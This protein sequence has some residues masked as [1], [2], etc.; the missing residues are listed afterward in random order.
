MSTQLPAF[1]AAAALGPHTTVRQVA[2]LCA[3]ADA[4]GQST[5]DY[6]FRLGMS[7]PVVSRAT[8]VLEAAGMVRRA[9]PDIDRRRVQIMLTYAGS[10]LVAALG[11]AA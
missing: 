5:Q 2:L 7:K 8:D 1:L 6:S 9:T 4:P 11:A 10:K 3:V